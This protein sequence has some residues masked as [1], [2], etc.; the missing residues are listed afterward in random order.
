MGR[1]HWEAPPMNIKL[2]L[3]CSMVLALGDDPRRDD[4]PANRLT[5]PV[6][7]LDPNPLDLDLASLIASIDPLRGT[8][9]SKAFKAAY[10]VGRAEAKQAM[11]D[12][13]AT[14]YTCGL[15]RFPYDVDRETGLRYEYVA[16]CE[17]ND[18]ILGRINGHNDWIRDYVTNH[19]WPAYSMKR[20]EKELFDLKGYVLAQEAIKPAYRLVLGGE[21]SK[22]PDGRFQI[23]PVSADFKN[24]DGSPI[25]A[26]G[27]ILT[28]DGVD[29]PKAAI[30]TFD[31][32]AEVIWGPSGSNF[33]VLGVSSKFKDYFVAGDA[34]TNEAL[35]AELI[36]QRE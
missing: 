9:E 25:K 20:W 33:F 1:S 36:R 8:K 2:A 32:P 23:R 16:G 22:S 26:I 34:R 24:E 21:P 28:V 11:K 5:S 3:A 27:F 13:R 30:E 18:E 12:G 15:A 35:R 4:A 29:L 7:L 6:P 10:A 31:H 14:I 17:V 19:F